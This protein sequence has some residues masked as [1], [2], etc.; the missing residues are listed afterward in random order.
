MNLTRKIVRFCAEEVCRQ[1]RGPIQVSWMVDAWMA[2][3]EMWPGCMA[4]VDNLLQAIILLGAH[5]E[6]RN[7]LENFRG[8]GVRVGNHVCPSPAEVPD[9]M[10]RWANN[11][12]KAEITPEEAYKELMLIHPFVDG[13]GRVGKIVYNALRKTL[14]KPAMP[15]NFFNCANP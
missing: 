8:V 9:L 10:R 15:P 13:N 1:G 14:N 5:V 7:P 6:E 2:A 12:L 4:N 11:L 3:S